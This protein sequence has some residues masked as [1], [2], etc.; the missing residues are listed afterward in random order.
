VEATVENA[1][2]LGADSQNGH[3]ARRVPYR[4]TRI[5]TFQALGGLGLLLGTVG[6]AAVLIRNA[7]ER[8][9]EMALLGAVGYRRPHVLAIVL[10]ENVLLLGWGLVV[11]AV[12]ALVAIAPAV[13]ERGG[14][15]PVAGS[16]LLLVAVPRRAARRL[17]RRGGALGGS[18]RRRCDQSSVSP[19]RNVAIMASLD[20]CIRRA[21]V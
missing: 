15:L 7:L 10:A 18:C 2:D 6:L 3:A 12:C 17:S 1:S 20:M 5:S 8:R 16:A 4:R 13:T 14:R 9:R 11:G 21:A 19:A